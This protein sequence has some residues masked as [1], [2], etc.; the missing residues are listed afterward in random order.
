VSLNTAAIASPDLIRDA[1]RK[2]GNQCIV[3]AIDARRVPGEERWE[4]YSHG[5]RKST[6]IDAIEWA[7][8]GVSLGAGEILLTSMDRD[9]TQAGYDIALN[10]R[11]S[12]AVE[13]PV[14]A[15][16]GAGTLDHMVDVLKEG[17]ASAVLAASIFHFGTF[18]IPQAKRHLAAAGIPVR[19]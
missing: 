8:R 3:L 19:E 4:V 5:G 17:G 7:R 13:V 12:D 6:G 10:R 18:T 1:A 15:S 14:I 9:G 11:I 16:G 2:F